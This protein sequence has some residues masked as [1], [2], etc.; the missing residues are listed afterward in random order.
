[1]QALGDPAALLVARHNDA[2]ARR[3]QLG[4]LRADGLLRSRVGED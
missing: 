4:E 3:A 2:L 1:M